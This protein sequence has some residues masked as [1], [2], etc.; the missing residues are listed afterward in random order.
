MALSRY[1]VR[2]PK[3]DLGKLRAERRVHPLGRFAQ[4]NELAFDGAD[5]LFI[6]PELFQILAL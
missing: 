4:Q 5:G 2:G 6:L 3:V 1:R